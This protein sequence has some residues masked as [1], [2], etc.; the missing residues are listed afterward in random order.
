MCRAVALN[1]LLQLT[2]RAM[3]LYCAFAALIVAQKSI[4]TAAQLSKTLCVHQKREVVLEKVE[5]NK[6]EELLNV[7]DS[8]LK[9]LVTPT[10]F[11]VAAALL[12]RGLDKPETNQTLIHILV[13]ALTLFSTLYFIFSVGL[14][15]KKLEEIVK[16]KLGALVAGTIYILL[17]IIVFLAAIIMGLSKIAST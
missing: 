1:K 14:V 17:Y 13:G 3:L 5:I 9:R 6:A 16:H 4:T 12:S 7:F 2:Q 15:A 11:L 8:S 10:A